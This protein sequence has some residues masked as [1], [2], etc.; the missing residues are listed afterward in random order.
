MIKIFINTLPVYVPLDSSILE[1]CE[2]VGIEIPRFCF[3]ERLSIAGNCRAC[4]IEVEK[5][6]KPVVSCTLPVLKNLRIVTDSP[7]V[8]K[9][10]ESILEFLLINHPLDCPICDQGG[11]C[12]LQDHSIFFGSDK[13]RFFEN[14]RSIE[15]KNCGPLV[16]TI[17]TR[18]I[19][20]SR[21]VRFFSHYTG[22]ED[23][24]ITNRSNFAEI[25]TFVDKFFQSELSGNIIDL[26]PVGAL[27]SKSY[28]F[29]ARAWELRT[30]E[31][32]DNTDAI[33]S[34][35]KVDFKETT[36][37]RILP[38]VNDFLNDGWITDKCRFNF[39]S[40]LKFRIGVTYIRK[41]EILI[42]SSWASCFKYINYLITSCNFNILFS[43][44][45][46]LESMLEVKFLAE[47]QGVKN[48]GYPRIFRL[49]IDFSENFLSNTPLI[50]IE[51]SDFCL[52][53]GINP[54]WEASALN[55]KLLRRF[56]NGLLNA[57]SLG[58]HHNNSFKKTILGISSKL[59][60]TISEGTHFLCKTL[61]KAKNPIILYGASIAERKDFLGLQKVLQNTANLSMLKT[62]K[63]NGLCFINQEQNQTGAF[64]LGLKTFNFSFNPQYRFSQL[65]SRLHLKSSLTNEKVFFFLG[66]FRN[67]EIQYFEKKIPL[68]SSLV[69]ANS[70]G[71]DFTAKGDLL[72]PTKNFLEKEGFYTNFEGKTQKTQ[73]TY[74]QLIFASRIDTSLLQFFR[75]NSYSI[76]NFYVTWNNVKKLEESFFIEKTFFSNSFSNK[77]KLFFSS[78]LETSIPSTLSK[79]AFTA[80]LTDFFNADPF[81]KISTKM[82]KCSRIH[83]MLF[84]NFF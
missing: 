51:K 21:C 33:G 1:A 75:K 43:A 20:C 54:K 30:I 57:I 28:A 36:L 35:I 29:V 63:Y 59:L 11:E 83:R 4:L 44:H 24:G 81:S 45:S 42:P 16:K 14:K 52:F 61:K 53:I 37:V 19:H 9:A 26:C 72:M 67:I 34:N 70:H 82:M 12:D 50:E 38:K 80:F 62:S 73:A 5:S 13:T 77:G 58:I 60:L 66:S 84:K 48:V 2:F 65:L 6:P 56:R 47:Q 78:F 76:S 55:L 8:K 79:I 40:F 46:D 64:I 32:I 68:K 74:A 10:R 49:N 69:I 7:L 3:H 18:C 39:D 15:N 17:M 71:C 41:K 25:G 22:F 23:L 27:T 31:S